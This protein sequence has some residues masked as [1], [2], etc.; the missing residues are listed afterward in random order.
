VRA[1]VVNIT[2]NNQFFYSL[3]QLNMQVPKKTENLNKHGRTLALVPTSV[4]SNEMVITLTWLGN[5]QID[6]LAS[7]MAHDTSIPCEVGPFNEVC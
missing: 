2:S 3:H 1:G 5:G 6:L 4:L 7:S